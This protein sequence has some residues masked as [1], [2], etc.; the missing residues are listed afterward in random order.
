MGIYGH[1][2]DK[3][4]TSVDLLSDLDKSFYTAEAV[5]DN[6]LFQD[7]ILNEA[8]GEKK[9]STGLTSY[10]SAEDQYKQKNAE[11]KS[12]KVEGEK[13]KL[14][15]RLKEMIVSFMKW[16]KQ[17]WD[18]L[19]ET[20][21]TTID[22]M[23]GLTL[24]DKTMNKLFSNFK[25]DHIQEARDKGWKGL[26][27][28]STVMCN[29]AN[30][31]D[32]EIVRLLRRYPDSNPQG[33]NKKV[34][35]I[36]NSSSVD[37]AK[38]AYDELQDICNKFLKDSST[39]V[40]SPEQISNNRVGFLH[41]LYQKMGLN[42]DTGKALFVYM[43]IKNPDDE[44]FGW[45]DQSQFD[46]CKGLAIDGQKY[47]NNTRRDYYNNHIKELEG[48]VNS[49]VNKIL[50]H[51]IEVNDLSDESNR[52]MGYYYKAMLLS[53]KS[54]LTLANRICTEIVRLINYQVKTSISTYMKLMSGVKAYTMV[55]NVVKSKE[56]K[57]VTA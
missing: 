36:S 48:F 47:V 32:S 23:R 33:L 4:Y 20:V 1:T 3:D 25:Y 30:I 38:K 51:K 9:E 52:I 57:A 55:S 27:Y 10:T 14:S 13:G 15:H 7:S 49:D 5:I 12:E 24:R 35:D 17:I 34:F 8:K 19:V 6:W 56:A 53:D 50:D 46:Q 42:D 22:K 43:R 11:E 29:P 31:S 37:D 18:K 54:Q 26:L 39:K 44:R 28:E 2:L 21:K 40:H 41:D 16:F 45:P